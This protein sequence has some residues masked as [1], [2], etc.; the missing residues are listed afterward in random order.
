VAKIKIPKG[1]PDCELIRV[2]AR[3]ADQ[4]QDTE[5][6]F[7]G[8][9]NALHQRVGG[10]ARYINQLFR[11]WTPHDEPYHIEP[12]FHIADTILGGARFELMNSAELFLLAVAIYGH[13]WGMAVSETEKQYIITGNLPDGT[14][15]EDLWILCDEQH[16]FSKFILEER[17]ATDTEGRVESISDDM[18]REYVRQT[19]ALRSAERVRRFFDRIDG[20]VADAGSRICMGHWLDFKNIQ[21]YYNYPPDFSLLG[22]TANIRALAVYLRL[23]DLFDLSEQ[24]TPYVIWKFVAPREPRSKMEWAKHRALRPVT[25]PDYLEGRII[26]VDGSTDDHEV[27]AALE[28]LRI[29]CE[30]QL[31]GCNDVLARMNDPRHQIDIYHIDWRVAARGFK[32]ISIRFE[33][34]RD[35]MFEMLS[36]EIYQGDRYIFLRELLQNSVD[37]IRMRREIFQGKGISPV[38]IGE[39]HVNVEH[40][41]GG[42]AV[43]TWRD[44]GIGM[45]EY[46]VRNY[47]AVVGESYYRS[48]DFRRVGLKMDPISRFGIGLLSCFMVGDRIEIDTLKDPYL[49]PVADP[50]RIVIPAMRR[51]FR[52]EILPR[53]GAREGTT[54]R[55]F[56]DGKKINDK[57]KNEPASQLEVTRYLCEVAGFVDFPIVITE[58]NRKTILLHPKHNAEDA[59]QRF[60]TDFRVHQMDLSYPWEQ[61]FMPQDIHMARQLVR[62]ERF[63]IAQDLGLE[64]YEGVLSYLVPIHGVDVSFKT[65]RIAAATKDKKQEDAVSARFS[66]ALRYHDYP[67]SQLSRSSSYRWNC[68]VY[69]HGILVPLA[70][71]NTVAPFEEQPQKHGVSLVVNLPKSGARDTDLARMQLVKGLEP[72]DLPISRAHVH[73]VVEKSIEDLLKLSPAERSYRLAYI[74]AYQGIELKTLWQVF[75]QENWPIGFLECGGHRNVLEWKDV[76]LDVIR[77]APEYLASDCGNLI[78]CNEITH[79]E[80]NGPLVQ[81]SGEKFA[82]T[83]AEF[84]MFVNDAVEYLPQIWGYPVDECHVWSSIRFL[85]APF[86]E[87]PPIVE[88]L[89]S[90]KRTPEKLLELEQL[91]EKAIEDPIKLEPEERYE[92]GKQVMR[93]Y[94]LFAR[95]IEF[96]R[97]FEESFAYGWELFNLRHPIV[98]ALVKLIASVEL[99]RMHKNLA[100]E[101]IGQLD[102][103][104]GH[105]DEEVTDYAHKTGTEVGL[106]RFHIIERVP[107]YK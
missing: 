42:D 17:L 9:L 34:H 65:S 37:A 16:H 105:L 5:F 7:L 47:L 4:R 64:E 21:D 70:I 12:L 72:W 103:A 24:R 49:P 78:C 48:E 100:P 27:Y 102:D 52:V 68:R 58:G 59:R 30:D 29:Y 28:D 98:Q 13:D 44:D 8:Q 35:R 85:R 101:I 40:G 41:S 56:V 83:R 33:F 10:E 55:V 31:R 104:L 76:A 11:D 53:E 26:R 87:W 81:W 63:D 6:D 57:K 82:V 69:R 60:G 18:W 106:R 51:Q 20:G 89:K 99:S 1:L 14:R 86:D 45:D 46:I 43:I 95:V 54:I 22:E 80:Y 96:P 32:P 84:N 23:V 88:R 61:V 62:E 91:L 2:L 36:E 107:V 79:D 38:S 94:P 97:P 75:P 74:A 3:K 90:P 92:L 39:I 71:S 50:L 19:H 77:D 93:R 66:D 67:R 15:Q 25:C 73:N